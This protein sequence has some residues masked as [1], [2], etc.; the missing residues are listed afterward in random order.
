MYPSILAENAVPT[1]PGILEEDVNIE[2]KNR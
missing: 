1:N 2:C